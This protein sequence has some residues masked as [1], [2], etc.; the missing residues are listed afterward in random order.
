M[1]KYLLCCCAIGTFFTAM[2]QKQQP[3]KSDVA[4]RKMYGAIKAGEALLS[5]ARMEMYKGHPSRV[6]DITLAE[7]GTYA[8]NV[9]GG[10]NPENRNMIVVDDAEAGQLQVSSNGF[11]LA[12]AAINSVGGMLSL[13]AGKHQIRFL[14]QTNVFPL[15]DEISLTGNGSDADMEARW[16]KLSH[17]L[18][19]LAARTPAASSAKSTL[20]A[21][22]AVTNPLATFSH[23]IEEDFYYTTVQWVYLT[24]GVATTF[25]TRNSTIDPV[26]SVFNTNDIDNQSW[27]NDDANGGTE[28]YLTLNVPVSG[29]YLLVVRPYNTGTGITN[30][31][32]NGTLLLGSAPIGGRRSYNS[33]AK[34]GVQ[35]FF[36]CQLVQGAGAASAPD[37]R[38]F[39]MQLSGYPFSGYNDDGSANGGDFVWGRASRIS[40]NYTTL[41]NYYTFTCAYS[42]TSYGR[43]DVYMG[44]ENSNVYTYFANLKAGDA[45]TSAPATGDYNC[46]SWSGGVTTAWHW[47]PDNYSVY[48]VA[49]N[50]LQGFD[51]F[52][53]NTPVKRYS[54]AWNYVRTGVNYSAVGVDLWAYNGS[55]THASVRRLSNNHPHGYDTESK[56][57][58][59][60]RTFHPRNA[61]D[62]A[63]PSYYGSVVDYYA[64]NNTYAPRLSGIGGIATDKA[65]ID[66]GFDVA[67]F[68]ALSATAMEKLEAW[69]RK[70]KPELLSRFNEL[71]D[72]W[73]RTWKQ[74]EVQSDP[75]RYC[76]NAEYNELVALCQ[77]YKDELLPQVF[78]R[79]LR[80]SVICNP[81]LTALTQERYG[82]LLEEVKAA[83]LSNPYDRQ[84]RFIV[85]NPYYNAI[86]H[87]EKILMGGNDAVVVTKPVA[88]TVTIS[89]N[90]VKDNV[91]V[92]MHIGQ[93]AT[94]A[95]Q[96]VNT[97]NGMSIVLQ[98]AL[99]MEAG[100]VTLRGNI[101]S[102]KA[103]P[104]TL[105]TVNVSV[106]GVTEAHK[107]IAGQ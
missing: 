90:P 43:C 10:L 83:Y 4:E 35:N 71:Y 55:Y 7:G 50:P 44:A 36:T 37:T 70:T 73:Q 26:L 98:K 51:N 33:S 104:G 94:V 95:V 24:A 91:L 45:I 27:A 65:A 14:S 18:Q 31:Y 57:G 23:D 79:Y 8:L 86:R 39:T 84:G 53:K 85:N 29:Y 74:N 89:P 41:N 69:S 12:K 32:Q 82:K 58:G 102:L 68:A 47:P 75:Q 81:L 72:A 20:P 2:A 101:S 28:S 1:K 59:T 22:R 60:A 25:E 106:N 42:A 16:A 63:A 107:L 6:F 19:V 97:Q 64:H 77:Q 15:I 66:A 88:I 3:V 54:G 38:L 13:R 9:I 5:E 61:L 100:E 96:V 49:G 93:K 17:T 76:Q 80:G 78:R 62:G 56:P 40:K 34:T 67:D 105:L 87:I 92:Q 30:I 46:I 21:A 52:Y 48:Y 11:Q 103:A 99:S